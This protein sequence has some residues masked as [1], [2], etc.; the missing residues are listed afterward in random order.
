VWQYSPHGEQA[1]DA[2]VHALEGGLQIA[3]VKAELSV[4]R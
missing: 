1:L 3:C 2:L 4:S